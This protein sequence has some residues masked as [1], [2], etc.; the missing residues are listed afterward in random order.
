[1]W[2]NRDMDFIPGKLY[3]TTCGYSVG[4]KRQAIKLKRNTVLLF[5][6]TRVEHG[7]FWSQPIHTFLFGADHV[8]F[9][10][11]QWPNLDRFIEGPV[12]S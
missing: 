2:Y 12:V 10:E 4:G 7:A 8:Y 3:K 9:D 6:E 5:I 11:A 1:M